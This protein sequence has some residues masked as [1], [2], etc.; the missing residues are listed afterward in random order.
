MQDLTGLISKST[1]LS[2]AEAPLFEPVRIRWSFSQWETYNSCPAKWKFKSVLKVPGKPP[3]PAAARGLEIHASIEEYCKSGI[4]SNLHGAVNQKY[5]PVFEELRNHENG[6][7]Y[8]EKKL[9]FD[10]DWSRSAVR[11]ERTRLIAI[12]DAVRYGNDGK[13]RVYE[14]K[15]GKPKDTHPDQR[16]LYAVVAGVHFNAEQVDVTTYYVED[17]APPQRISVSQ[18][19]VEKL[20]ALWDDRI[21]QMQRDEFCA[22]RPGVHC[23]WCDYAKKKGGP[24]QFGG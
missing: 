20:K 11:E 19:G 22:P 24:C 12:L 16:K 17:T 23:N 1:K 21:Q 6:D 9:G 7:V 5:L 10:A 8:Y 14:W 15:S 2:E 4:L 3:G 13:A 18:S